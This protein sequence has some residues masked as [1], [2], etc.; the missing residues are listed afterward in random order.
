MVPQALACAT[1]SCYAVILVPKLLLG[2]ADFPPKP[3]LG[4][5]L[6]DGAPS[7]PY[8]SGNARPTLL[9]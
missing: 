6:D 3:C 7:A 5:L 4:T 9:F 8:M 1:E 2:K